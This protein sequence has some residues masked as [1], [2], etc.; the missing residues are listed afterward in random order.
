MY[1]EEEGTPSTGPT[2]E[3]RVPGRR[4]EEVNQRTS[5]RDPWGS[6]ANWVPVR[7]VR[8]VRDRK[9][10]VRKGPKFFTDPSRSLN[11]PGPGQGQ[12]DN[13]TL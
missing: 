12:F 3:S 1:P 2:R 8:M 11:R 4:T 9:G 10:P 13:P 6:G 7:T 5:T